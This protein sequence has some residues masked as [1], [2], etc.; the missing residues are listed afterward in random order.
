MVGRQPS[1][2]RRAMRSLRG[3][4]RCMLRARAERGVI[5]CCFA[6]AKTTQDARRSRSCE[7]FM[8]RWSYR[9]IFHRWTRSSPVGWVEKRN[10]TSLLQDKPVGFRSS[11]QP[12]F[13][14]G[15]TGRA[16]FGLRPPPALRVYSTL[17][18]R[19]QTGN[20]GSTF[21]QK[22]SVT[23][24]D[25]TRFFAGFF[26]AI[27]PLSR[28]V[29]GGSGQSLTSSVVRLKRQNISDESDF[30]SPVCVKVANSSISQSTIAGSIL[31]FNGHRR[32]CR[33]RR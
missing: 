32:P 11:T 17:S 12:T 23:T 9:A 18:R 25:A 15:H 21:A 16:D 1:V 5:A 10:P 33:N 4:S 14:F 31:H 3:C 2:R 22:S 29:K 13:F 28:R 30:A 7:C 8:T 20:E 6:S 24:H 19:S 26:A 27:A